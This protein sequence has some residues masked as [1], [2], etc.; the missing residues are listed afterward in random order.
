MC[1]GP[2]RGLITE[3]RQLT[4]KHDLEVRVLASGSGVSSVTPVL[5]EGKLGGRPMNG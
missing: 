3:A 4:P 1:D 2:D 5:V